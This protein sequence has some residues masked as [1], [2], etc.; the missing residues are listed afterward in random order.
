MSNVLIGIIGVILFI[1]LALAGALFL[2]PRFQ[3]A[4]NSSKASAAIQA[5]KQVADAAHLYEVSEGAGIGFNGGSELVSKG[6]LKSVP[7]VGEANA[8]VLNDTGC[9]GCTTGK[10]SGIGYFLGTD[11]NAKNVCEA[12]MRQTGQLAANQPFSPP[13]VALIRD[14]LPVPSGCT[15]IGSEYYVFTFL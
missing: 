7:K 13:T 5:T 11:T 14:Q 12:I 9:A 2:G 6:Y 1:G 3:S 10:P 15:R 4:S 8:S